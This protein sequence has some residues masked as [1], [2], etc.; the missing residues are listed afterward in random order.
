MAKNNKDVSSFTIQVPADQD[1]FLQARQREI[2]AGS[3]RPEDIKEAS[4]IGDQAA[5][6]NDPTGLFGGIYEAA[7]MGLGHI[8]RQMAALSSEYSNRYAQGLMLFLS[9]ALRSATG[10][11]FIRFG[12]N[13][14]N[15][16]VSYIPG[17]MIAQRYILGKEATASQ[18]QLLLG[19]NIF[20]L[21]LGLSLAAM[22]LG[23]DDEEE[24]WHMEG[25]WLDLSPDEVKQR[26]AAGFEPFTFWEQDNGKIVRLS[27]KQWPTAGLVAAVAHMQDRQRFAPEKWESAGMTGHLLAAASVGMLQVKEAAAMRGLA[28]LMGGNKFGANPEEDLVERLAK[29]PA[30]F[31][32]GFIPTLVKDFDLLADPQRYKPEGIFE[33]FIRNV[34]V[35]RRNLAGGRPELNILGVP[36]LQDRKPW[37]RTYTQGEHG[38]AHVILS[39]LMA[40]GVQLPVPSTNKRVFVNNAWTTID[41]LGGEAEWKYQKYVGEGYAAFLTDQRELL[42]KLQGDALKRF[43][44]NSA[45]RIKSMAAMRVADQSK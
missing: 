10:A 38:V 43:I 24:G 14:A 17:T 11:K 31:A 37:S 28:E 7:N 15:D 2:L 40:R 23:K 45:D 22:F 26:R 20:G 44:S 41:A 33:D 39:K 21:M 29:V 42:M 9:G 30:N 19:K 36:I 5:Y 34:P 12:A 4:F 35:V 18:K 1:E 32:G 25:G 8:E 13:F 16:T 27:Y 6:Q 3:L